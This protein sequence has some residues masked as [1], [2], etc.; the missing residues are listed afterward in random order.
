MDTKPADFDPLHTVPFYL[1][2]LINVRTVAPKAKPTPPEPAV[3]PEVSA[4]VL[5]APHAAPEPPHV[6]P[7]PVTYELTP[8]EIQKKLEKLEMITK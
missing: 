3:L 4:S 7:E 2:P 5:E 1:E 6:A 8:E